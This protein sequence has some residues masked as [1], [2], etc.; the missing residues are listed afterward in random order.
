[1]RIEE[2]ERKDV[3]VHRYE[4]NDVPALLCV[5]DACFL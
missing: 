4:V 1:M 3:V 2:S 5:I